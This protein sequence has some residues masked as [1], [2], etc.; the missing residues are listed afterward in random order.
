MNKEK[1]RSLLFKITSRGQELIAAL[2]DREKVKRLKLKWRR[3]DKK[4]GKALLGW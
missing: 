2:P 3:E 1:D 4:R